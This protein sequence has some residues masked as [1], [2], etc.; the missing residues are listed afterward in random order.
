MQYYFQVIKYLNRS[1]VTTSR[2]A[3]VLCKA[4]SGT[5]SQDI[6]TSQKGKLL[7]NVGDRTWIICRNNDLWKYILN[8]KCP[9]ETIYY[10]P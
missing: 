2:S 5:S 6:V 8:L 9:T 1:A 3:T 7:L 4:A 10:V